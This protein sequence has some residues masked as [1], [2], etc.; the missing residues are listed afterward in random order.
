MANHVRHQI[1]EA[2]AA[3][4]TGLTTTTTNVFQSR[5]HNIPEVDL[6][7]LVI[8][9]TEEDSE[10]VT[11]G[12]S[13]PLLDRTL[14]LV[15]EGYV[16]VV[17]DADDQADTIAKEVEIAIA[18]DLRLGGLA[19]YIVLANTSV[20]YDGEADKNAALVTLTFEVLYRTRAATPDI[21]E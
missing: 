7:A 8:Y 13:S 19:Q 3:L 12:G 2:V 4:V 21:A 9:T 20:E 15:I 10:A 6:P 18:G 14:S 5:Q 1:R 17:T 11:F 16:K